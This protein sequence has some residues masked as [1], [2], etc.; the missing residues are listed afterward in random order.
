MH[1]R[2]KPRSKVDFIVFKDELTDTLHLTFKEIT[3]V[4]CAIIFPRHFTSSVF[5]TVLKTTC[6]DKITLFFCAESMLFILIP[7][8]LVFVAINMDECTCQRR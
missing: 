1:F 2:L 4:R 6:V 7:L 3:I 5:Q 8:S